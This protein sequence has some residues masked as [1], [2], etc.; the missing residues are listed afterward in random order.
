VIPPDETDP[1]SV[2]WTFGPVCE[3]G[4]IEQHPYAS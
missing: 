1:L 3:G 2:A 4:T